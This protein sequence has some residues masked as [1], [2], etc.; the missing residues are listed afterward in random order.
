MRIRSYLYSILDC[1]LYEI[2]IIIFI[3]V[4]II[5][6]IIIII[7]TSETGKTIYNYKSHRKLVNVKGLKKK[8]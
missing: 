2:N 7:I 5:I 6:I 1:I 4:I 3:I 8:K